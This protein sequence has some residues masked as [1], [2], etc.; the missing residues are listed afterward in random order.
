MLIVFSEDSLLPEKLPQIQELRPSNNLSA[1]FEEC[2]NY[3]YNDATII[4][5]TTWHKPLSDTSEI[6][7]KM[8]REERN[9]IGKEKIVKSIKPLLQESTNQSPSSNLHGQIPEKKSRSPYN[10]FFSPC[11]AP[12]YD[13]VALPDESRVENDNLSVTRE[14]Q[15]FL[16]PKKN[17]STFLSEVETGN[18]TKPVSGSSDTLILFCVIFSVSFF[19]LTILFFNF[20]EFS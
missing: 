1:V 17:I 5:T 6:Y 13:S 18:N 8:Q 19:I 9:S 10:I 14:R 20:L 12:S 16:Q 3:I 4:T 15:V 11:V 7:I 2:H